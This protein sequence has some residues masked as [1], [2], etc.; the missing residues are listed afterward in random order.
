MFPH[1]IGSDLTKKAQEIAGV[2]RDA[3]HPHMGAV[4]ANPRPA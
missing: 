2:S 1:W 3:T 4:A